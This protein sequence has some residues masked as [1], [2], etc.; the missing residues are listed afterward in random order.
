[1]TVQNCVCWLVNKSSSCYADIY[2]R[3]KGCKL[4]GSNSSLLVVW[5]VDLHPTFIYTWDFSELRGLVSC[6]TAALTV[7][8]YRCQQRGRWRHCCHQ[9]YLVCVPSSQSQ[10]KSQRYFY[11]YSG[12]GRRRKDEARL[13]D[14]ISAW[15]S[16]AVLSLLFGWEKSIRPV[17]TFWPRGYLWTQ[18]EKENTRGTG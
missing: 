10:C 4:G 11:P 14:G 17:K 2:R 13:M 8:L 7:M 16:F 6:C 5:F 15:V 3:W 12:G 18:M 1:M 9:P